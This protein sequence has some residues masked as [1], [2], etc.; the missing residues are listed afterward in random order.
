MFKRVAI[1][2]I[3]LIGGSIAL[4]IKERTNAEVVGFDQSQ[5][6]IHF[7]L[8]TKMIDHGSTEL[9]EAVKDAD[10]VILALPVGAIKQMLHRLCQVELSPSCVITDVGS[11]KSE[12]VLEGKELHQ[13]G[14]TFIGGH[15]MAGSHRSGTTA[16]DSFLFENAYYI[17][18]PSPE[19][20]SKDIERLSRFLAKATKAQMLTMDAKEHDR[21]VG[22]ISHLPHIIAAGLVVQIGQYNEQNE[23]F[24]RLAAGGFRDL[25]R[26][27]SSHPVM[28]R[29]V[30]LSNR[31][32]VSKLLDDWIE[33]M[34]TVKEWVKRKDADL[35]QAFFSQA[36]QLRGQIDEQ[37]KGILTQIYECYVEIQDHPGMIGKIATLLGD[38]GVN[39]S[40]IGIMEN[41]EDFPGVLRLSFKDQSDY[42][43]AVQILSQVG[44]DVFADMDEKPVAY[45]G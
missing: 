44:F 45:K 2:G 32:V 5:E 10:L 28:W 9:S 39:L 11:T 4:G 7:A 12:I 36:K 40:N 26:I 23:W 3:G 19:T 43:R 18:T 8:K 20:A 13:R 42:E 31:D 38:H 27:A 24:H 1:L 29:D 16:A 22:A 41:R 25:T 35:L 34:S 30:L 33:Q 14:Y 21:I 15:P 17:L 37:S 6:S